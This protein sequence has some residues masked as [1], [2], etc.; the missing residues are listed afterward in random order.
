MASKKGRW[1][2]NLVDKKKY[3][4][5]IVILKLSWLQENNKLVTFFM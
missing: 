4:K 3:L 2:N 1:E 5:N